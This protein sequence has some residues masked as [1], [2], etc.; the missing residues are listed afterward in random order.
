MALLKTEGLDEG[1]RARLRREAQAMGRLGAHAHIVTLYD[2]GEEA[3]QPFMVTE[4]MAGG[5]VEELLAQAPEHRLPLE[6]ALEIAMQ[7]CRGLQ[8]AHGK[9]IVHR[10]LKPGNVWLT[11]EGTAKIGDF[12]L[13]PAPGLLPA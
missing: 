3:G 10:D 1:A 9:G 11:A 13:A 2:L 4:Y 12:G 5:I 8:F 6:R 7:V